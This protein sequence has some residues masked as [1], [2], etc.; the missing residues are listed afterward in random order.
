MASFDADE[1][2]MAPQWRAGRR[3]ARVLLSVFA[4]LSLG[5][6]AAPET[7]RYTRPGVSQ[8]Q[9]QADQSACVK[10][11]IGNIQPAQPGTAVVDREDFARC[12]AANGY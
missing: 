8:A 10:T 2:S 11:S 6:Y 12:M 7:T 9:Q 1:T 3:Q 4:L 5:G